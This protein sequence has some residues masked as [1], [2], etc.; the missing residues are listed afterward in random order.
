MESRTAA[1]LIAALV[2][3]ALFALSAGALAAPPEEQ[4]GTFALLGGTAQ[5]VSK[6]WSDPATGRS[7]TLMVR[8]F[9]NDEPI[10][11]Y[12]IDMERLMH[13]VVIRDDFATFAHL[14]P[15]FDPKTGTFS[16][17]FTKEPNHRY[18]VYADTMPNGIGQQVF[19]FMLSANGAAASPPFAGTKPNASATA[20]PYT[21]TLG[22]TT[23]AANRPQK[24]TIVILKGN[25]PAADLQTYLGAA[26]HAVF[27]DTTTL[28]YVHLHPT[29]RGAPAM[30]MSSN[31][32]MDMNP[33]ASAGASMEMALPALPADPYKLWIQFRGGRGAV[34]TAPFT[35]LVR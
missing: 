29:V 7:S 26:A 35:L 32:A 14:H 22:A 1:R 9:R 10:L 16:Q 12:Q 31:A 34:Y 5:I 25:E 19:R 24:L 20:G 18:Y 2:A 17:L 6:L 33:A 3:G 30:T 11:D 27:I 4:T 28:T 13:L 23:I 8:Q 15:A 21:V